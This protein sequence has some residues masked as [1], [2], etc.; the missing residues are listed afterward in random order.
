[1]FEGLNTVSPSPL[2]DNFNDNDFP[3]QPRH[4][5]P[6]SF[7]QDMNDTYTVSFYL[8]PRTFSL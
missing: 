5:D 6:D 7:W 2:K 1:M 8:F 4:H 3:K